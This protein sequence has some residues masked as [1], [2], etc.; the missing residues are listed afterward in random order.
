M[1]AEATATKGKAT[2][3]EIA[4]VL[5]AL[6]LVGAALSARESHR[7]A[8]EKQAIL[9]ANLSALRQA[10][11]AY[12][13][14]HGFYPCSELDANRKGDPAIFRRQLT[15]YTDPAGNVSASRD[16]VFRLGP[17][18]PAF[19]PNPYWGS[20]GGLSSVEVRIDTSPELNPP[21]RQGTSAAWYYNPRRGE[22]RPFP[23][24]ISSRTLGLLAQSGN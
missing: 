1:R 2:K 6:A 11:E 9:E 19:P 10:L 14:D 5:M 8:R 15:W 4:I 13:R 17:Y 24:G 22:I 3:A 7:R 12:R 20:R 21:L 23:R 18:L 16:S